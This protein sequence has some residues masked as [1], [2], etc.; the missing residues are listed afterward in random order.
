[1]ILFGILG[2]CSAMPPSAPSS[3]PC[4]AGT[5]LLLPHRTSVTLP[6][7]PHVPPSAHDGAF[8]FA[9]SYG[10]ALVFQWP[11][12]NAAGASF[13][14]GQRDLPKASQHL[15]SCTDLVQ[16]HW[17]K[18]QVSSGGWECLPELMQLSQ[19]PLISL[20]SGWEMLV[21][22]CCCWGRGY[23]FSQIFLVLLFI[24]LLF[25]IIALFA[26]YQRRMW[27]QLTRS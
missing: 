7:C 18:S 1:M 8:L 10:N 24:A 16:G 9:G 25:I 26:L 21:R 19:I 12:N 6:S 22:G 3:K 5:A 11:A 27:A 4:Q 15:R 14:W 13:G 2:G 17:C 23:F 20:K